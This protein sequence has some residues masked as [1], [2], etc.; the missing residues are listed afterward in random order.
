MVTVF[1]MRQ[2]S[3]PQRRRRLRRCVGHV[4]E[5]ACRIA[6]IATEIVTSRCARTAGE[7]QKTFVLQA[8][9]RPDVGETALTERIADASDADLQAGRRA[10]PR[11]LLRQREG[12]PGTIA[13][14][15]VIERNVAITCVVNDG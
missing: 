2:R 14:R 9:G 15:G 3:V 11:A 10:A 8:A 1:S 4:P 12:S 13:A 5:G 7:R 6:R